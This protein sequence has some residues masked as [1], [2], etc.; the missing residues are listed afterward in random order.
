MTDSDN[1]LDDSGNNRDYVSGE[2]YSESED[3]SGDEC[4]GLLPPHSLGAAASY[5]SFTL[6]LQPSHASPKRKMTDE[7][8]NSSS[9]NG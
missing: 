6:W 8:R 5:P 3:S 7:G 9:Q 1:P 2:G 4:E